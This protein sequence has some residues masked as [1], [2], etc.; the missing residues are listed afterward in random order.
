MILASHAGFCFGVR[1]AVETAE[2]AAPAITLGPIIHNPQVVARLKSLGI[3]S[4]DRPEEIPAGVRAVIRSH[5]V[6]REETQALHARGC[7]VVDATCPF[8]ARI[9]EMARKASEE[10]F[11]LIVVGEANHP[12]V[13]G[14]LG[15]TDGPKWAVLSEEDVNALPELQRA[16]VVSQTTLVESKFRELCAL[17]SQ[18]S[19]RRTSTLRFAPPRGT[20][21]G[22]ASRSRRGRT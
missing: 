14:I 6:S 12:E 7:Q 21:S 4:A 18:K 3:T 2:Q 10:G 20:D 5:G 16:V 9:H 22:S 15:W 19:A 17:L 13:Q 1:R 8:V 11:P